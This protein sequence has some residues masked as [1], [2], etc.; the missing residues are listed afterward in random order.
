MA[1]GEVPKMEEEPDTTRYFPIALEVEQGKIYRWCGCGE[2]QT[3]PLCDRDNCSKSVTFVAELNEEVYFCNC[4]HTKNPPWCDG[5][6]ARVLL[7]AVKK[8]KHN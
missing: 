7:E 1:I 3:Q 6:H 2:S 4:K 8:R 5:S